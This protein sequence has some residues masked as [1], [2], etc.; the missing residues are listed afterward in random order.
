MVTMAGYNPQCPCVSDTNQGGDLMYYAELDLG[1]R[2]SF[3]HVVTGKGEKVK[4]NQGAEDAEQASQRIGG[5]PDQV[6]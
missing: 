5:G 4:S 1:G 6:D 2:R 3:F